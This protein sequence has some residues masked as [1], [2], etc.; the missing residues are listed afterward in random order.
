[1]QTTVTEDL[2]QTALARI[3][4]LLPQVDDSTPDND[5]KMI[6]LCL[7]SDI[8]ESYETERYPIN[9][10]SF[11]KVIEERLAEENMQKKTLAEKIGVSASRI[12]DFLSEKSE[13]SLSQ[14][15]AICRV[16][17]IAP[18]IALQL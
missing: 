15:R 17:N 13:P 1:M 2:Y 14:A 10:P 8:V 16:L 11:A 7:F 12:S 18:Q 3:E 5:P 4:V 9:P 6:E